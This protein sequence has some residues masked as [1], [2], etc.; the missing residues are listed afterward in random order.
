MAEK[1]C[2]GRG[3]RVGVVWETGGWDPRR[4]LPISV[5]SRLASV[6][7]VR[8]FSLQRGPAHQEAA[9]FHATDISSESVSEA[10]ARMSR[11]DL[12][13]SVDTMVAHL[14]GALGLPVWT[15]LH[16]ECD[17]RWM[18]RPEATPWY[19]T[20]RLFRQTR[21]GD[22]H[23]VMDKVLVALDAHLG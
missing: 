2:Q 21:P 8:L 23:G 4:S 13:I 9:A 14:G 19:P 17:W 20:M 16:S 1:M 10:A 18:N 22:W 11:L 15:L 12:I 7:G 3:L 6:P 5:L